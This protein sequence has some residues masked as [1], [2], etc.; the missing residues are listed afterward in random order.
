MYISNNW[1]LISIGYSA[2]KSFSYLI[3][4]FCSRGSGWERKILL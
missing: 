2:L 4:R 1:K 3:I